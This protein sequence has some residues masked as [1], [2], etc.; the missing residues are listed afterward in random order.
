MVG[1]PVALNE[2][3]WKFYLVLICPSAVYI[4]CIYFLFPET[5]GRTLEE[6]V[7][8]LYCDISKMSE[9]LIASTGIAVR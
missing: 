6:I 3:G 4:A 7:S 1:A 9:S 8:I 2:I 5:K